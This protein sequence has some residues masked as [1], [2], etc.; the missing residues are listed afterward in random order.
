MGILLHMKWKDSF[1]LMFL[2][3]TEFCVFRASAGYTTAADTSEGAV[4]TLCVSHGALCLWYGMLMQGGIT[5]IL[6]GPFHCWLGNYVSIVSKHGM[7]WLS[8]TSMV[9]METE[10]VSPS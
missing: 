10:R 4:V 7:P 1:E 8:E 6:T 3:L 2:M 5:G 9:S